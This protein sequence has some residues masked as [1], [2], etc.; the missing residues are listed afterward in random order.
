MQAKCIL[1]NTLGL[2]NFKLHIPNYLKIILNSV[3]SNTDLSL[4]KYEI[5]FDI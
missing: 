5:I 3:A 1:K 2:H 4:E